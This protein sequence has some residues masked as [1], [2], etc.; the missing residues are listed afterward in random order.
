MYWPRAAIA[1]NMTRLTLRQ[2]ATGSVTVIAKAVMSRRDRGGRKDPET[3]L[4]RSLYC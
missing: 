2:S 4:L 3:A 1:G